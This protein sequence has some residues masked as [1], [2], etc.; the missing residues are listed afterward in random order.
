MIYPKSMNHKTIFLFFYIYTVKL[1]YIKNKI[2]NL[3]KNKYFIFNKN[4]MINLF[5]SN[6]CKRNYTKSYLKIKLNKFKYYMVIIL[7]R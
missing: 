2:N 5:R 4:K 1:I 6:N 7:F 3:N